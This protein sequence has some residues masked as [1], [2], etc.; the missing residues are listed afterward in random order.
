M[1]KGGNHD[2][3][4]SEASD[5][6]NLLQE[7]RE[8]DA[9]AILAEFNT[10]FG[11]DAE[12]SMHQQSAFNFG[13]QEGL[14]KSHIRSIYWRLYLGYFE[15]NAFPN[16]WIE[17]AKKHRDNYI[18][19]MKQFAVNPHEDEGDVRTNNPL[20]ATADSKWAQYY[21]NNE[22]CDVIRLD[23]QRTHQN[24]PF[25][26][27]PVTQSRMLNILFVWCK[28]RTPINGILHLVSRNPHLIC[29]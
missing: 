11:S 1:P 26:V 10:A 25:F 8:F 3:S 7:G 2:L 20:T 9:N 12:F 4:I 28:V 29:I 21:K 27:H 23:L 18:A 15:H 24:I 16:R 6:S 14:T 17:L 13:I 22:L 19:L 5:S